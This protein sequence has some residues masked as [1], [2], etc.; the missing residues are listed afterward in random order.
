MPVLEI[1]M[2]GGKRWTPTRKD[3]KR[4]RELMKKYLESV[5]EKQKQERKGRKDRKKENM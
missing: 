4:T 1:D 3:E 5:K 2:I